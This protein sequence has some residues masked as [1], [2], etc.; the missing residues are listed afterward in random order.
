MAAD[1]S[2]APYHASRRLAPVLSTSVVPAGAGM[3]RIG[4]ALALWWQLK[5]CGVEGAHNGGRSNGRE[6]IGTGPAEVPAQ[7]TRARTCH[8]FQASISGRKSEQ[9]RQGPANDATQRRSRASPPEA[10][11]LR[12]VDQRLPRARLRQLRLRQSTMRL[13]HPREM[14]SLFPCLVLKEMTA[15]SKER[16]TVLLTGGRRRGVHPQDRRHDWNN[17]YLRENR[18]KKRKERAFERRKKR[19]RNEGTTSRRNARDPFGPL[20]HQE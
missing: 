9:R 13:E 8:G 4:G 7:S 19:G 2:A 12:R 6:A 14:T 5:R 11:G 18:R 16:L 15:L 3:P 10:R 17:C 1:P 20:S